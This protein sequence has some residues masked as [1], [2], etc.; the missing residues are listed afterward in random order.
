MPARSSIDYK[1][2]I[3]LAADDLESVLDITIGFDVH[4]EWPRELRATPD[5]LLALYLRFNLDEDKL[6]AP[7]K[8]DMAWRAA[9]KASKTKVESR[10]VITTNEKDQG[11]ENIRVEEDV[12]YDVYF[13]EPQKKADDSLFARLVRKRPLFRREKRRQRLDFEIV[14]VTSVVWHPAATSTWIPDPAGVDIDEFSEHDYVSLLEEVRTDWVERRDFVTGDKIGQSVVKMLN[15]AG[16]YITKPSGGTW[17]IPYDTSN[18]ALLTSIEQLK[19]T[20]IVERYWRGASEAGDAPTGEFC[21]IPI[22]GIPA[23]VGRVRKWAE[24]KALTDLRGAVAAAKL[25]LEAKPEPTLAQI[26]RLDELRDAAM[27]RLD[28]HGDEVAEVPSDAMNA[29]TAEFN[30]VRA[31]VGDRRRA[32]LRSDT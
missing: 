19:E 15:E 4:S 20:L 25:I 24:E 12:L 7:I 32:A 13:E 1:G 28:R 31:K 22:A 26:V 5:E 10:A 17:L 27:A 30:D 8:P 16:G 2:K 11:G 29:A 21:F 23:G 18:L 9:L 3:G 14:T 6:P